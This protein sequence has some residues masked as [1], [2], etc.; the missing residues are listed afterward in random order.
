MKC[1]YCAESIKDEAIKC[2]YCGEWL[3]DNSGLAAGGERRGPDPNDGSRGEPLW[4]FESLELF[5]VGFVVKGASFSYSDLYELEYST[6]VQRLNGVPFKYRNLTFRC[7]GLKKKLK[8]N[9]NGSFG[10]RKGKWEALGKVS[11]V[12]EEKSFLPRIARYWI[13]LQTIGYAE[14][15]SNVKLHSDGTL[16]VG[17]KRMNLRDPDVQ[18]V[19]D[20]DGPAL[21]GSKYDPYVLGASKGGASRT[22]FKLQRDNLLHFQGRVDHAVIKNLM[23]HIA[24]EIDITEWIEDY[25]QDLS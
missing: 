13:Q 17:S 2:R 21:G 18:P 10:L 22:I 11:Q 25:L 8:F 14:Y 3:Q 6:L 7:D 9:V 20:M 4:R 19:T 15:G 5:D 12:L 23:A 1:P 24:G 16:Q